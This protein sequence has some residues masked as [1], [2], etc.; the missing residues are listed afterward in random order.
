VIFTPLTVGPGVS[1]PPGVVSLGEFVNCVG[2]TVSP[3]VGEVVSVGATDSLGDAVSVGAT[4]SLGL[5]VSVGA[6]DSLGDTVSVGDTDS[7]GDTVSVGLTDSDGDT[8]SVG[9]TDSLGDTVSVGLTDSDGDT[10]SLG[11]TVSVGLTDSDGETDSLGDTVSDGV[12]DTDS[13]GVTETLGDGVVVVGVQVC[14]RTNLVFA[15]PP[16]IVAVALSS[17]S[18]VAVKTNAWLSSGGPKSPSPSVMT[19]AESNVAVSDVNS[20]LPVTT[21]C[22]P[23][24]SVL[25]Q[26]FSSSSNVEF[27]MGGLWW[28]VY[29]L[30]SADDAPGTTASCAP[31]PR[32]RVARPPKV[33]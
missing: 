27:W 26:S 25:G 12:G 4:D 19:P 17:V 2:R 7:L 22:Q 23:Q 31:M 5:T 15:P 32:A 14:D 3:G 8:V 29:V 16:T 11:D 6:T 20:P 9:L 18:S 28:R 10:D 33:R 30:P 21:K 13:L 24:T 1:P